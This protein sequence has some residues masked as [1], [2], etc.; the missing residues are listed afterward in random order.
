M[1]HLLVWKTTLNY[2]NKLK[3]LIKRSSE[4]SIST[5]TLFALYINVSKVKNIVIF[6]GC[7][8][9]PGSLGLRLGELESEEEEDDDDDDDE[10]EEDYDDEDVEEGIDICC[11]EELAQVLEEMPVSK[12]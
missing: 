5:K 11:P 8:G 7:E 12:C 10:D 3:Y 1:I 6:V 4:S 2:Q 9:A